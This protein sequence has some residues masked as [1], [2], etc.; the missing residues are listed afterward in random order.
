[1]RIIALQEVLAVE[2]FGP[3]RRRLSL[4]ESIRRTGS[5]GLFR[6]AEKCLMKMEVH[7]ID[8]QVLS[9]NTHGAPALGKAAAVDQAKRINDFLA[10]V[11]SK[12]P[13]RLAG[14]G[15]LPLQDP[16]AAVRE[17]RVAIQE[18]GLKGFFANGLS[19][20]DPQLD[21]VWAE[22]EHLD[23][24]F[25][26]GPPHYDLSWRAPQDGPKLRQAMYYGLTD[27]AAHVLRIV[28][29]GVFDRHPRAKLIVGR[30][31]EFLPSRLRRLDRKYEL[32][33]SRELEHPPSYYIQNNIFCTTNGA[34]S[35]TALL[36]S[37]HALGAEKII[38][39]T[40]YY[41]C[42]CT[43]P[44]IQLLEQL[45]VSEGDR[46]KIAHGNAERILKITPATY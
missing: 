44:A 30:T 15:A 40:D 45:P 6:L 38:F 8:I 36:G 16:D 26:L 43:T 4:T 18:L 32:S 1:M 31:H 37:V 21:P 35:T 3:E 22:L 24:P 7:N 27:T 14:L 41:P 19:L 17:L 2:K 29:R 46:A 34:S 23:V 25:Y 12:S 13:D 20:D 5:K 11:T 28:L 39:T 33:G 42:E 9:L 10:D